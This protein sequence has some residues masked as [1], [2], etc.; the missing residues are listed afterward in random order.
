MALG[1]R[2]STFAS[3]CRLPMPRS[4]S[5]SGPYQR[6]GIIARRANTRPRGGRRVALCDSDHS[7]GHFIR[8]RSMPLGLSTRKGLLRSTERSSLACTQWLESL[9]GFSLP[10]AFSRAF[11]RY[12]RPSGE[13]N[14]QTR[15]RDPVPTV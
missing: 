15:G 8:T 4:F 6:E 10:L 1:L 14:R 5:R 3:C 2:I 12:W 13:E 9:I 7:N 11:F